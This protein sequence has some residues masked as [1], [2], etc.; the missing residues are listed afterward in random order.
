MRRMLC[1]YVD[2]QYVMVCCIQDG[3]TPLL[4]ACRHGHKDVAVMLIE[5]GAELTDKNEVRV[6]INDDA[7]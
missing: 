5:R 1:I 7:Y 3:N 4:L 6:M 2:M